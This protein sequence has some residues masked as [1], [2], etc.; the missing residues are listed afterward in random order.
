MVKAQWD[1][2]RVVENEV[3]EGKGKWEG[4]WEG[5]RQGQ[6]GV[7]QGQTGRGRHT[8]EA[9]VDTGLIRLDRLVMGSERG[10][11]GDG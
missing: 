10:I 9:V 11:K 2:A 3:R 1:K 6:T 8:P 4:G 7:G 5:D